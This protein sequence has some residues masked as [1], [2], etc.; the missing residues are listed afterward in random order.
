MPSRGGATASRRRDSPEFAGR[1]GLRG[2]ADSRPLSSRLGASAARAIYIIPKV[3]N[4]G[5]QL[6]VKANLSKLEKQNPSKLMT[7]KKKK[8]DSKHYLWFFF[9]FSVL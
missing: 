3:W 7:Q 1:A 8:N 6:W 4:L 9:Y 2:V 5:M